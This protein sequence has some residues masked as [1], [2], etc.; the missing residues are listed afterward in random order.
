MVL[1]YCD[2]RHLVCLVFIGNF[3]GDCRKFRRRWGC[4]QAEGN[5]N[6]LL[7]ESKSRLP[8]VRLVLVDGSDLHEKA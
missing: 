2:H 7:G 8:A 6:R 5:F 3:R 1:L 4:V